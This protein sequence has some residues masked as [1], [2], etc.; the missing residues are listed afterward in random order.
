MNTVALADG[1]R[2]TLADM[3]PSSVVSAVQLVS[4]QS[5]VFPEEMLHLIDATSHRRNEF[6]T[7]RRCLRDALTALG[8]GSVALP[9]DADGLPML[10]VGY[11]GSISHSRGLCAAVAAPA[12]KRT[13]LGLDIE[14]TT[15]LSVAAMKRVVHPLEVAWVGNDQRKASLLFSMKEAFYKAQ[16]VDGRCTGNF[17]DLALEV[18]EM[19]QTAK[20]IYISTHFTAQ[21]IQDA[22]RLKFRYGMV[23]GYVL[24]LCL[25]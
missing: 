17:H 15:R 19:N 7:G 8:E 11:L 10:P 14:Q 25:F 16:Y 2:D 1:A 18:D 5:V 13:Y 4:V 20:V 12:A 3:L 21:L 24:S 22:P 23:E 9:P 6:A